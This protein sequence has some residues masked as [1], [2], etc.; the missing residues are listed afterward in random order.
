MCID[1]L[2]GTDD[3]RVQ[4]LGQH[5]VEREDVGALLAADANRVLEPA[6]I[7]S[8]VG[9]PRRSS[10]AFVATVVPILTAAMVRSAFGACGASSRSMPATAASS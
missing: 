4:H 6:V 7:T 5:D 10:S 2:D 1:A 3:A 9:S 8:A